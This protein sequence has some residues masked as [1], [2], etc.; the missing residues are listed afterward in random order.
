MGVLRQRLPVR[1]LTAA[2]RD[3]A[4]AWCAR[5]R[6]ANVFVAARIEEGALRSNPGALLGHWVDGRLDGLAWAS[7]NVVPV[8]LDEAGTADVAARIM[9][10]RRQCASIFGPSEQVVGLWNRLGPSWG[11]VRA[12]R[13]HQPLLATSTRPVELGLRI[14]TGVRPARLDEVGLVVPAAAHMFTEEIGYPPFFGSDRGYRASVAALIRQG[15]TFIRVEDGE[16]IFK[17]DVGSLALG[18]AQV[19]G[20]WVHPRLR[21]QG[22]AVPAMAAVMEHIL[23]GLAEEVSLYVND[24]NV[25]ARATYARCG[26]REVGAFTTVL[27]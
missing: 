13:R 14:D 19:Q 2:D 24:Y 5:D 15:H 27:L 12:I 7:A 9:R 10:Q 3:T 4:L 26:F 1:P 22:L 8:G 21:G 23:G 11:P 20:V 16:V 17:A 18:G 6:P 25:A